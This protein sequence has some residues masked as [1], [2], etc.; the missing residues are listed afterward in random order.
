MTET[1]PTGEKS[2]PHGQ[3][4]RPAGAGSTQVSRWA[5]AILMLLGGLAGATGSQV[6]F[7]LQ[8]LFQVAPERTGMPPHPPEIERE[9]FLY[10]VANHA[11]G[12][13]G[14]GLLVGGGLGLGL[15]VLGG[16]LG[17]AARA[18]VVGGGLGLLLG[19]VGGA[20]AFL[21]NE[22][23]LAAPIDGI[24]KAVLI[25]SPNWLLLAVAIAVS[26]LCIRRPGSRS[27]QLL[28]SAL[29]AGFLAALLYPLVALL[30]FPAANPDRPIPFELGPRLL[31]FALGGAVLGVAA[32]RWLP[33]PSP[34][35]P[36]TTPS[37]SVDTAQIH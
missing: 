12:F 14:L 28:V 9:M 5:P 35:A 23:L 32:A 24:F 8:E 34:A 10:A 22:A 1:T 20:G 16:S 7:Q 31:C 17:A 13:G 36:T 26:A 30:V 21:A 29:V 27:G 15:G 19:A 4:A 3:A 2:Q 37:P 6:I 18:L 33:A 25:H 11:L